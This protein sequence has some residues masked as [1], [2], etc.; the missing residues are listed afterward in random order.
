MLVETALFD[1][2]EGSANR[3]GAV[4]RRRLVQVPRIEPGRAGQRPPHRQFTP[5]GAAAFLAIEAKDLATGDP[6]TLQRAGSRDHGRDGVTLDHRVRIDQEEE[7]RR[8]LLAGE[9]D[10]LSET[11]IC[12]RL[13]QC[14]LKV[15]FC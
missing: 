12:A 4:G 11:E 13:N 2:A 6:G 1:P 7:A 15:F 14:F 5:P 8:R 3:H 10:T 9:I